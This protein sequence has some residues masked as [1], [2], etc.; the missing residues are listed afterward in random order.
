MCCEETFRGF[1]LR[2]IQPLMRNIIFT[3][4]KYIMFVNFV[5][6]Y[7][8]ICCFKRISSWPWYVCVKKHNHV[9]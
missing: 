6:L 7:L 2:D 8:R 3:V 5:K 1:F 4:C 9:L